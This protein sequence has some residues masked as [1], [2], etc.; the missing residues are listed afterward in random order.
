MNYCLYYYIVSSSYNLAVMCSSLFHVC[1]RVQVWCLACVGDGR[2]I[3]SGGADSMLCYWKVSVV[4]VVL[5][6]GNTTLKNW[7]WAWGQGYE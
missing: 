6:L 1:V 7:E 4:Q 2:E 3:V 5:K